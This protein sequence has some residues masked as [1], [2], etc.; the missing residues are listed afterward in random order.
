MDWNTFPEHVATAVKI[1]I[2]TGVVGTVVMEQLKQVVIVL[3][4]YIIVPQAM[5]LSSGVIAAGL[6]AYSMMQSGVPTFIAVLASVV[7]LSM[8]KVIHDTVKTV[9][10]RR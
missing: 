10:R 6:A 2:V 8:P 1:I 5:A 4:G 7:A 9:D 3:A